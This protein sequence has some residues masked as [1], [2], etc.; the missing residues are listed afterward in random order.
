MSGKGD[1]PRPLAVDH[2]TFAANWDL[3]FK[4]PLVDKS[5][6]TDE[7]VQDGEDL[8]SRPGQDAS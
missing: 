4:K 6:S 8:R 5:P 1:T 7:E 3:I 2:S